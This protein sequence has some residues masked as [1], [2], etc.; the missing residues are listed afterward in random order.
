M[1]RSSPRP[2]RPSGMEDGQ[3]VHLVQTRVGPRANETIKAQSQAAFL[4][5]A[6]F[7]RRLIYKALKLKED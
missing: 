5:E 1:A 7:V 6:A 3:W 4:S 2:R